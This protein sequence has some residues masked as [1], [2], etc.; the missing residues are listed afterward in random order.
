[1]AR[2]VREQGRWERGNTLITC[3]PNYARGTLY[4]DIVITASFIPYF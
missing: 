3:W 4:L 2:G 1:M